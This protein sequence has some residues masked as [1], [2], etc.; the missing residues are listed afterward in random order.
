MSKSESDD[1]SVESGSCTCSDYNSDCSWFYDSRKLET[2]FMRFSIISDNEQIIIKKNN[3]KILIDNKKLIG[4][5]KIKELKKNIYD[6]I[7]NRRRNVKNLINTSSAKKSSPFKYTNKRISSDTTLIKNSLSGKKKNEYIDFIA[8]EGNRTFRENSNNYINNAFKDI[9]FNHQRERQN[10][11]PENIEKYEHNYSAPLDQAYFND[12]NDLHKSPLNYQN[13]RKKFLK[14]NDKIQKTEKKINKF[15]L[16][17]S[18]EDIENKKFHNSS[19]PLNN[20]NNKNEED[21]EKISKHASVINNNYITTRGR[22]IKEKIVK[23]TKQI[24]LE[25]GQTIKPKIITKRKL[26]PNTTIIKNEDGTESII[27]ENTV[28]TTVIVNEIIDSS[29]LYQDDYPLDVQL[30]KQYITKVYKTQIEK[31]PYKPNKY[32]KNI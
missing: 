6:N 5:N 31:N 8:D 26:K 11:F 19:K 10:F 4:I 2:S 23:E 14:I 25:P 32:Y 3:S 7:S 21:N 9:S 15:K 13:K 20:F 28:L 29:Q 12:K 18:R 16:E 30:V 1:E 24:T 27:I 22:T 17:T